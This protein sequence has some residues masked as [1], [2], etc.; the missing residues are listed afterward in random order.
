V[1]LSAT[2]FEAPAESLLL[3]EL[4][5]EGRHVGG[6]FRLTP[7]RRRASGPMSGFGNRRHRTAKT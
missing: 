7:V 5:S 1:H 6:S 2:Q 4:N 3:G